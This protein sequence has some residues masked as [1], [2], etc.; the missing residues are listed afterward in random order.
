MQAVQ[1]GTRLAR[2]TVTGV[3]EALV[4]VAIIAAAIFG[5]AVV[6]GHAPS[7]ADSVLAGKG[8]NTTAGG[9]GKGGKL[10]SGGSFSV[11]MV[12]DGNGDGT[13]DFGDVITYDVSRVTV[14]NPFITTSCY[15]NGTLV[16]QQWAGWYADYAWP[17][18]RNITLAN[19]YWTGGA[20]SCTAVLYNT[21]TK[22]TFAV[23]G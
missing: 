5:Y 18:A 12:S 6:S 2:H 7:G 9:G 20:G 13:A 22:L 8:G 14:A 16:L 10:P 17:G 15:Q 11:Q 19:E 23:G 1:L 21:S 4:I 3:V